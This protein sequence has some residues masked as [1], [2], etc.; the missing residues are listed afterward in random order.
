MVLVGFS[1]AK[2]LFLYLPIN[3]L[4]VFQNAWMWIKL[5]S[6][7]TRWRCVDE[8]F[9]TGALGWWCRKVA[10][11]SELGVLRTRLPLKWKFNTYI[12]ILGV[13]FLVFLALGV[14][15][16]LIDWLI[17]F[18]ILAGE[19]LPSGPGRSSSSGHLW[20]HLP[21]FGTCPKSWKCWKWSDVAAH[22]CFSLKLWIQVSYFWIGSCNNR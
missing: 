11:R 14:R 1:E 18:S 15:I 9:I 22:F 20:A 7:T 16:K 4:F 13:A 5:C 17:D 8:L 12:H 19:N 10:E 3:M 21:V 2:I 6:C